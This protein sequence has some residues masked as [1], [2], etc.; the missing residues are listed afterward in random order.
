MCCAVNCLRNRTIHK[1]YTVCY[2]WK[3][4]LSYLKFLAQCYFTAEG[5]SCH[6]QPKKRP[7]RQIRQT[8]QKAELEDAGECYFLSF[9]RYSYSLCGNAK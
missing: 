7:K 1:M 2:Y 6:D 4:F 5:T 9:H 3:H 8:I